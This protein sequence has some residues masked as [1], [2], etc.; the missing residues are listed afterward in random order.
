M[1]QIKIVDQ[2]FVAKSNSMNII[3]VILGQQ[4]YI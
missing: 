3:E 4:K 1:Y 2:R